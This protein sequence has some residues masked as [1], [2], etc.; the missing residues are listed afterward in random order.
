MKEFRERNPYA[1]GIV[2]VLALGAFVGIAFAVGILHLLE[3]SYPVKA[4]FTD[5][6]GITSG[7]DVRVA[8][9]KAGRVTGIKAD[10]T[11]GRVVI[12]MVVNHGVHLG[13]DTHAEVALETLLG[14]RYVL[15]SGPVVKPYLEDE[16]EAARTIPN[17]RTKTPFDIFDITKVGTRSIEATDTTKLNQFI[18]DLANVTD[19]QHDQLAQL[20]DGVNK[21]S[22]AVNDRQDQL[23]QLLDRFDQLSGLLADKDQTLVSLIDQSQGI[24]NLVEQRRNDIANGLNA[25]DQLTGSVSTLLSANK[26]LLNSILA[27]LHPTL[28]VITKNQQH[29]DAALSWIGPGSLGLAKST[30]HGPWADIYVRA[31]GP[32]IP[33]V[34]CGAIKPPGV[35]CPT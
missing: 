35:Q 5:A 28:D 17:D 9:I 8:G 26:G 18:K 34:L 16:P 3:K 25:T 27:T 10:R 29:V 12:S 20:L 19:G 22:T 30:T 1:I 14:T 15:L 31:V 21:V 7:T 13:P 24:L 32:D 11:R 6:A 2:C 33:G 4:E 23:R